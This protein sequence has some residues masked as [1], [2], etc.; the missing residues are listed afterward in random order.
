MQRGRRGA[1]KRARI[2]WDEWV[3]ESPGDSNSQRQENSLGV[4]TKKFISLL[5]NSEDKCIDLNEAVN[6]TPI[7]ILNVQKRRI[8]D[9]TNVLEGVGLI[10]KHMK[11]KIQW[12]GGR[13]LASQGQL[14]EAARIAQERETLKN[15]EKNIDMWI[16]EM[17][18]AL[19]G[20]TTDP[21]YARYAYVTHEDVKLLGCTPEHSQENLILI[22]APPGSSLE[23]PEPG[24]LPAEEPEKFQIFLKNEEG[25]IGVFLISNEQPVSA[26]GDAYI[27]PSYYSSSYSTSELFS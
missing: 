1:N 2:D 21:A 22:K 24:C 23:V 27:R 16:H 8:Y 18:E 25:D 14:K 4:L 17:Q 15:E 9:I 10:S 3:E 26:E 20:M 7:Q 6:V 13:E 11:N 5:Q 19:N 12:T